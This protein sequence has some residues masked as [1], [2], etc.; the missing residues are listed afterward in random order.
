MSGGDWWQR[1]KLP[2]GLRSF[3]GNGGV[4]VRGVGVVGFVVLLEEVVAEVV[5]EVAPDGVDVIGVVLGVVVFDEEG[6]AV[7]AVVVGLAGLELA[8]PGEADLVVAGLLDAEEVMVGDLVAM[9]V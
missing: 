1:R 5:L 3:C 7:D 8:G 9:A 2:K 6:W 4:A